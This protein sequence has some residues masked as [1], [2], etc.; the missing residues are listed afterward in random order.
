MTEHPMDGHECE[1]IATIIEERGRHIFIGKLDKPVKGKDPNGNPF[2]EHYC[3][4]FTTPYQSFV[5]GLDGTGDAGL[6]TTI[7]AVVNGW[8]PVNPTWIEKKLERMR[9]RDQPAVGSY[10]LW[11]P[12]DG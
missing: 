6:F 12:D 11:R 9:D 7:A 3:L 2:I 10:K 1:T 8:V 4:H 5:L